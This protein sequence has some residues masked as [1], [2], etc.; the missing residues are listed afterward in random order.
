MKATVKM[1]GCVVASR[2]KTGSD[3][4]A[5]FDSDRQRWDVAVVVRPNRRRTLGNSQLNELAEF[6]AICLAVAAPEG[7]PNGCVLLPSGSRCKL[8]ARMR[9]FTDVGR[10]YKLMSGC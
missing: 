4:A 6:N 1:G 8:A 5:R 9:D 10:I 7:I 3:R 2:I